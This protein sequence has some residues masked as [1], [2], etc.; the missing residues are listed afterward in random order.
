MIAIDTNVLAYA[1]DAGQPT[2]QPT[3]SQLLFAIG[4]G[5]EPVILLWQV[6]CEFLDVLRRWERAGKIQSHVLVA[7]YSDLLRSFPLI[8]SSEA[9]L[10]RSFQLHSR[11]SLSHWDSLLLAA[12]LEAGVTTLYTEDLSH[13]ARYDAL[14]V[15]NP[16]ITPANP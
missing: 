6:A 12:A 2:K 10:A 15:I 4:N 9:V 3:A 11:Y 8:L 16:F 5:A 1:R 7:N 14:Q 13:S